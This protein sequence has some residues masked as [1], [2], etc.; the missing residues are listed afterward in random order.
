MV[1]LFGPIQVLLPNQAEALA[2]E[3]KEYVLGLV[4]ALGAACALVANPLWGALSDRTTSRHGR[5][6]PWIVLGVPVGALG[7]GVLAVAPSVPV[8]VLGWCLVQTALGAPW[9]ALTAAVPDQVPTAQRGTVAGYLGFA[10]MAGVFLAIGLA[11]L[12]PG[13]A[14]Y[15]A[16]A[17][18]M[19]AVVAPFVLLRRDRAVPGHGL[20]PWR[21]RTF[22]HSFWIDPRRYPDFGWAWLTR[23]LLNLSNA[24]VLVYLL[25]FLRDQLGRG[26]AEFDLLLLGLANACGTVAAVVWAGVWSDRVGRRKA[27]VTASGVVMGLAALLIATT[28]TL[29]VLYLAALVLGLGFGVYTSVDFALI[30]EVLPASAAR[31]KD[32]GVLNIASAL[33]QVLA[34]AIAAPVVTRVGGYPVLFAVAGALGLLGALLVRRIVA[35]P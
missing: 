1:G 25:Y 28:P 22:L 9:A 10:Q 7:L 15:L 6:L 2:P 16:C 20:G 19:T 29:P 23:F 13:P 34:P 3:A 24:L 30:T 32:L 8:M 5:R 4:T 17:L 12:F 26:N 14:G 31:G 33:P 27:F 18:A 21:W 35:V 11:T